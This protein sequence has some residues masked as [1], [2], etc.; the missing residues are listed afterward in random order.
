MATITINGKDFDTDEL[1]ED[2]MAHIA[3]IRYTDAKL[4][5]LNSE[6]AALQTAR[7]SYGNKLSELLELK[8]AD[9]LDDGGSI[10]FD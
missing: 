1:S 2:V 9:D 5:D 6:A 8:P 4:T 7:I 10:S 3:S